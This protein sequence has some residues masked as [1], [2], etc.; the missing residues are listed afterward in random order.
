MGHN[1]ADR[2]FNGLQSRVSSTGQKGVSRP[3]TRRGGLNNT[4][5][6]YTRPDSR[7]ALALTGNGYA[8]MPFS[9]D[10]TLFV[11]LTTVSTLAKDSKQRVLYDNYYQY[12]MSPARLWCCV[13]VIKVLCGFPLEPNRDSLARSTHRYVVGLNDLSFALYGCLY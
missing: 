4:Q 10:S 5:S 13:P 11:I 1:C 6:I 12:A 8:A 7:H 2:I 3:G 9:S